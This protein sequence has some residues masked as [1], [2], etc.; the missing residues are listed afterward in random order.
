MDYS[1]KPPL[2]LQPEDVIETGRYRFRLKPTPHLPHGWDASVLFEETQ[3]TL[4]CSDLLHQNGRSE[5]ITESDIVGLSR[6]A[7]QTMQAG[8]LMDYM[9]YTTYSDRLIA[10]LA[11]LQPVTL[12]TM[13]GSS[14]RGDGAQALRDYGVAMREE[15]GHG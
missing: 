11:A 5:P 3:R 13:H 2:G 1:D 15:M 12:A 14:F 7:M 9:P 8:P 10:E 4:L 6:S